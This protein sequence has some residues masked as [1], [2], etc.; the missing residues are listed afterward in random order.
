MMTIF[1]T[2]EGYNLI[3][4]DH[5]NN[6]NR[7]RVCLYFKKSLTLRNIELYHNTECQLYEVS[8]KGQVG[9]II[10]SYCSPSQATS[11]M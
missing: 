4:V 10:V 5:P 1:F 11:H 3:R 2:W 8:V 6:I 7:G 9:F